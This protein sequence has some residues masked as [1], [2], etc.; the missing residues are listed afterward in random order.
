MPIGSFLSQ[1]DCWIVAIR[2]NTQRFHAVSVCTCHSKVR[3]DTCC[4][5]SR[6]ASLFFSKLLGDTGSHSQ[7][8]MTGATIGIDTL[9]T[10]VHICDS[11]SLCNS[12]KATSNLEGPH[13]CNDAQQQTMLETRDF[14]QGPWHK[15]LQMQ[16]TWRQNQPVRHR[17]IAASP[18]LPHKL[19]RDPSAPDR[20]MLLWTDCISDVLGTSMLMM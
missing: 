14:Y 8:P 16:T 18:P 20:S 9:R 11:C 15:M 1:S 10:L 13:R 6:F 17:S 5:P 7:S 12:G 2:R 3:K 4:L 19:L